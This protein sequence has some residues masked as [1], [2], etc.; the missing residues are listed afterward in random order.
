[1]VD[2]YNESYDYRPSLIKVVETGELMTEVQYRR[3][4]LKL[5]KAKEKEK[6][7]KDKK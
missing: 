7:E 2:L 5:K 1:V 6:E 3:Y 4:K